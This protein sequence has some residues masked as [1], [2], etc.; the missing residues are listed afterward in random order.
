MPAMV[1]CKYQAFSL[2]IDKLSTG[3]PRADF[4]ERWRPAH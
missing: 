2:G 1:Y 3:L 4:G